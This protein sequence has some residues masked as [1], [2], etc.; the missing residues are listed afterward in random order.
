VYICALVKVRQKDTRNKTIKR[1]KGRMKTMKKKKKKKEEEAAAGVML[2]KPLH[3]LAYARLNMCTT[4]VT[5]HLPTC[6]TLFISCQTDVFEPREC[7]SSLN[8]PPVL[9]LSAAHFFKVS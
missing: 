8:W 2:K 1:A 9:L 4:L 6:S 5:A 3:S 7:R